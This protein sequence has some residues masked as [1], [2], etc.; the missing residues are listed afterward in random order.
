M[1]NKLIIMIAAVLCICLSGCARSA[2]MTG[3]SGCLLNQANVTQ[4]TIKTPIEVKGWAT[5]SLLPTELEKRGYLLSNNPKYM[6]E[7]DC[8]Q[9]GLHPN[10]GAMIALDVIMAVPS[11]VLPVPLMGGQTWKLNV[12]ITDGS[13]GEIL[14]KMEETIIYKLTGFSLWGLIGS[15]TKVQGDFVKVAALLIDEELQRL[16]GMQKNP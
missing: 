9:L 4:E 14:S 2:K 8:T 1:S 10:I 3:R 11:L 15:V 5:L 13:T 7:A 12:T 6:I 16:E